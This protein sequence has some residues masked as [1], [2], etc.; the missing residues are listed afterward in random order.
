TFVVFVAAGACNPNPCQNGGSCS[1]CPAGGPVCSCA[2]DF[3]G[4]VCQN[5]TSCEH[6]CCRG[7]N[8]S[9]I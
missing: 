1:V 3:G 5:D 7:F 2:P 8:T 4:M 9:D 6:R